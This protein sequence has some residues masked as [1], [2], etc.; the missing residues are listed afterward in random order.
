MANR[1]RGEIGVEVEG[2]PYTLRPSFN[3]ICELENITGKT[4]EDLFDL[5][6]QG[7]TIPHPHSPRVDTLHACG[8]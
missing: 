6:E 8:Q 7:Q 4:I 3:A 1:E 5:I 2:K